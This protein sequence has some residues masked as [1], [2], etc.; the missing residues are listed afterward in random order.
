MRMK[1][2]LL[3]LFVSTGFFLQAQTPDYP[4]GYFRNPMGIPME[5]S[6]N[7][8]ELRPDHW[9]MGLDIRTNAKE[10]FPVYAAAEGYIA[11]IGIRPKSFGRFIIINHPNGLST[12]YGH[13]NDFFPEL[14]KY[15]R[16]QQYKK[17]SWAI[18]L[19]LQEMQFP[20]SKGDFIAY[21][22]NTGGS[23]GPH[24]HFEIIDTKSDKRLNPLLFDFPFSDKVPP[25]LIK[26]AMYDRS[27]SVYE[28]SPVF[29]PLKKTDSGYIIPKMP[30][31]R[32]S[33]N[34]V[35]FALQMFD[36]TTSSSSANGVYAARFYLDEVP[37]LSFEIDSVDYEETVYMNAHIDYKLDYNGG[38]Y[39]Q[40]L[41]KMPGDKGRV[42]KEIASDGV[43]KFTD[44]SIHTVLVKVLDAHG[45]AVQ[46]KFSIRHDDSLTRAQHSQNIRCV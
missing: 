15:V 33:L 40:H 28:Q 27:K 11:Q 20:V 17:E 39:L 22:G 38:V 7:F 3:M 43:L 25:T 31:I 1:F 46:L 12:L 24:L 37:Q 41:S 14:E 8:G 13:L 42:Y 45:N 29:F 30:L 6:A 32:T 35:S 18:E 21:S 16:E 10:N 44:T 26:L 34:K 23:Q 4:K 9:H 2:F 19:D 36:K 5:L